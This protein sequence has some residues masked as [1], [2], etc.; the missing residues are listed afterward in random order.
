MPAIYRAQWHDGED[1]EE[2]NAKDAIRAQV[3]AEL[4]ERVEET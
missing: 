2:D 4:A 3:A 1:A